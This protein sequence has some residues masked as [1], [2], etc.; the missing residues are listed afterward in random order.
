LRFNR[1]QWFAFRFHRFGPCIDDR[2]AG[3][4]FGGLLDG[5]GGLLDG[6]LVRIGGLFGRVDRRR[7]RIGGLFDA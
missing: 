6:F 3:I 4:G 2:G 5:L 7:D 1:K